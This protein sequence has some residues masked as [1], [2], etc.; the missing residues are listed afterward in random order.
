MSLKQEHW[1]LSPEHRGRPWFTLAWGS[2][3][4]VALLTE[5]AVVVG[6][7]GANEQE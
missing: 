6:L 5:R 7:T 4:G 1:G 2:G 3:E